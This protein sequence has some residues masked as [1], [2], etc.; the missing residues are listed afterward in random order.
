MNV[1]TGK[2]PTGR[3]AGLAGCWVSLQPHLPFPLPVKQADTQGTALGP[4][5]NLRTGTGQSV[6]GR[7]AERSRQG[8]STFLGLAIHVIS[9]PTTVFKPTKAA[10][11]STEPN[12]HGCV[13]IKLYLQKLVIELL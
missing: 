2:K 5:G 11:D 12:E 4:Q 9:V 13:S 10:T 3:L 7:T 6:K 8:K 1:L